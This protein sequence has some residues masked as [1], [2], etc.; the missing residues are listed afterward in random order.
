MP[1]EIAAAIAELKTCLPDPVRRIELYDFM[2]GEVTD[3]MASFRDLPTAFS[4]R[5]SENEEYAERVTAYEQATAR[6]IHLL[7][8]GAFHSNTTDHDRLWA[9]CVA[10]LVSGTRPSGGTTVLVDMQ[11]YPTLLA[12]YAIG[13]GSVASDRADSVARVFGSV[14]TRDPY[15][16]IR[17]RVVS[18]ILPAL[19][20][21]AMK[22]AFPD[23]KNHKT[24]I[25]DHLLDCLRAPLSDFAPSDDEYADYFD[26]FEYLVGLVYAADSGNGW[27]PLGRAVWRWAQR[28]DLPSTFVDRHA[29]LLIKAGL[30]DDRKHLEKTR[31]AYDGSLKR[32]PLRYR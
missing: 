32:S 7:V 2:M 30:F 26:E 27:G 18:S 19:H 3:A 14:T 17:V 11:R 31:A 12:L 9:R 28:D 21:D 5:G 20:E 15:R 1:D 6:L 8:V 4:S 13:L 16:S 25:S 29:D 23:L 24:P 22:R 10:R